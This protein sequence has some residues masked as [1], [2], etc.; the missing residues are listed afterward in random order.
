MVNPVY[1]YIGVVIV[2]LLV[3]WY[4]VENQTK[5]THDKSVSVFYTAKVMRDDKNVLSVKTPPTNKL[6]RH[7]EGLFVYDLNNNLVGQ[8]HDLV[9]YNQKTNVVD[10]YIRPRNSKLAPLKVDDLVHI[11]AKVLK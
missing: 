5:A 7:L 1:I 4:Y 11:G 9:S 8:V 3:L 6:P 10:M 2:L